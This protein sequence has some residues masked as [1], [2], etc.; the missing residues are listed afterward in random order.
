MFVTFFA[1][2]KAY[3][4]QTIYKLTNEE[5]RSVKN[6]DVGTRFP[7]RMTQAQQHFK[8]T[9]AQPF[10]RNINPDLEGFWSRVEVPLPREETRVEVPLPKWTNS[11]RLDDLIQITFGNKEINPGVQKLT[12][13]RLRRRRQRVSRGTSRLTNLYRV[14]WLQRTRYKC[15]AQME[16]L[17]EDVPIDEWRQ[18]LDKT[19]WGRLPKII[20]KVS[21]NLI[22]EILT[23]FLT[24]Q[25]KSGP[26]GSE[27]DVINFEWKENAE[28]GGKAELFV[29]FKF[30]SHDPEE[31]KKEIMWA[32]E[33][34]ELD[35]KEIKSLE[36]DRGFQQNTAVDRPG[37][38][39]IEH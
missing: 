13:L 32:Q 12:R 9:E 26:A 20:G 37:Q 3:G 5:V 4:A 39:V 16:I 29:T 1:D 6:G 27:N 31:R 28:N 18:Y 14:K 34:Y 36:E 15:P 38:F 25:T 17:Q 10:L 35:E 24:L 7:N 22:F 8:P 19:D 21:D 2:H 23:R 30:F 11:K 33:E